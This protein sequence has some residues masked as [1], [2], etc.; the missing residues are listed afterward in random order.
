MRD[1]AK[2]NF[3]LL[4]ERMALHMNGHWDVT[5]TK[6]FLEASTARREN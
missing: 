5:E 4:M 3:L 2:K 1:I 6:E